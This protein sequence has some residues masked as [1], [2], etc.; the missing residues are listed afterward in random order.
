MNTFQRIGIR[1]RDKGSVLLRR[2]YLVL[3]TILCMLPLFS[4]AHASSGVF[5]ASADILFLPPPAAVGGNTLRADPGRTVY[6]AALVER[7]F[8]GEDPVKVPRGTSAPL[9]ASGIREGHAVYLPNAGGQWQTNFNKPAITIE[10]VGENSADVQHQL[11]RIV[12]RLQDLAVTPQKSLGVKPEAFIST[13]LSPET[14]SIA[15]VGVRSSRA[16]VAL[17][18][19]TLGLSVAAAHVGDRLINHVK[20]RRKGRL[21]SAPRYVPPGIGQGSLNGMTEAQ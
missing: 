11:D 16:E 12:L 17:L 8:N 2:W 1:I 18:L 13:E 21:L 15:H 20:R 3:I 6:Y 19:L 5:Y 9:Y 10:V 4:A 14:P 7:Q